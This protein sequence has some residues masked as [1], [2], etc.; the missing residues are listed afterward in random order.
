MNKLARFIILLISVIISAWFLYPSIQWYFLVPANQK[1]LLKMSQDQLDIQ[2]PLIKKQVLELKNIRKR[3]I[4]LGLDLQGGVNITLQVS[5]DDLK[6]KLLEKYD[7]DQ[8]KVDSVFK[9]E[10]ASANDRL[11]E[12]LKNRMDQ[13]GVAEPIIRKTFEGRISVELPGLSNPQLIEEALS[14]VGLL[15]FRIVDEKTMEKLKDS[16]VKMI[17]GI[18]V[19]REDVPAGFEIPE[20]SEWVAS[21]KN[22]EYGSPVME[23]WYV[24]KKK[25]EMDGTM[26]KNA[27][28][29]TDS[30]GR[31][32]VDFELTSEGSDVFA[33]VT[34]QNI[35]K[36][37]AIVLDGKIKS[38]PSIRSE[39]TGGSGEITGNFS[40]E[41]TVF[42]ANVLKAGALPVKLE[43]AQ[44]RVI[45]PSLGRDSINDSLK[46]LIIGSIVV[47]I[48]IIIY[49][50]T[51]GFISI[52]ALGFHILYLVALMAG[53]SAT[54][55]LSSIAGVVLTVG[56]AVDSNI[57]IYERIREEL[58]RSGVFKRALENGYIHAS[59]TIW[60][61]NMTSL[62]SAF[63]LYVLGTGTIK[64]FGLTMAFGIVS[65]IFASLFLS[66]LI[67]DWWLDTFKKDSI[68]V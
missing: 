32:K 43:I 18:V 39:I 67:F 24:L 36:R 22:D 34:A 65:N 8:S 51:A 17:Q 9:T 30:Y 59:S 1:E 68:S 15:E 53:V 37:L 6:Q 56:M 27:R 52:I 61:S 12:V 55:T 25:V 7:F 4:S 47:T 20:D 33:E 26:V 45:G 29:N 50:R 58:R 38:A 57:I 48:F 10:F 64:G 44:K 46:A 28:A 16:N 31:P 11:L 2:T 35:D 5:E 60:D 54:L 40:V 13:F 14:K 41:E 49:Y 19:S 23:G 62:I 63:V 42:L 66:R 3:I 21:W